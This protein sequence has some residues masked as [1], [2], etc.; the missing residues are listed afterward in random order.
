M[1]ARTLEAGKEVV[2]AVA[3]SAPTSTTLQIMMDGVSESRGLTLGTLL[4]STGK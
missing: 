1:G 3:A 4:I 2:M